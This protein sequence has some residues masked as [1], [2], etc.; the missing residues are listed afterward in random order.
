[1]KLT[2]RLIDLDDLN[3]RREIEYEY[4]T[5]LASHDMKHLDISEIRSKN[6]AVTQS[7]SRA[8]YEEGNAGIKFGSNLDNLPCFALFEGRASLESL[9]ATISLAEDIE[10]LLQV[11]EEFNLILE[12][13]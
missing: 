10:E 3:V 8:L 13:H 2:G 12:P 7:I 5:L 11:C 9:S 1:M 6:R 4:A